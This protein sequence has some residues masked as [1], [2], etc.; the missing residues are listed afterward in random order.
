MKSAGLQFAGAVV[1]LLGAGPDERPSDAPATFVRD[2]APIVYE[3]CSGCHRPGEGAPFPLTRYEEVR[4]RSREI[5]QVT[6]RGLMPPWLPEAGHVP[7][8]GDR[9]LRPEEIEAFQRWH[10]AGAPLGE[11]GSTLAMPPLA[12][13]DPDGWRLGEPDL[14]L[15]MDASYAV[16]AEGRDVYRCFVLPNPNREMRWVRAVEFQPDNRAVLHHCVLYVDGSGAARAEDARSREPGYPGMEA[17]ARIPDGQ[18]FGWTPGKVPDPGHADIAWRLEPHT[19]VVLQLHLRPSGKPERVRVRLGLTFAAGPPTRRPLG[20]NISSRDL[21]IPAGERNHVVESSFV[22]PVEVEALGIWPHVHYLGRDLTGYAVLPDGTQRTL[23]HIPSWDFDW[24]EE[25]LFA[26]PITLSAGTRV[27]FRYVYDNSAENPL[28]PNQPP[29]RV[30]YGPRSDQEMAE[31]HL[32]VVP[33]PEERPL[34]FHDYLRHTSEQ[35]LEYYRNLVRADPARAEWEHKVGS[36]LLRL[37]RGAEAVE[38]YERLVERRP[39]KAFPETCLGEARLEAGDVEGAIRVLESAV[40]RR[41]AVPRARALLGQAYRAQGREQEGRA[42]LERAA[43]EAPDDAWVL[44]ELATVLCAAGELAAAAPLLQRAL[45]V[46]PEGITSLA[47][48]SELAL[49]RGDLAAARRF[50]EQALDIC[51]DDARALAALGHT[52][53]REANPVEAQRLLALARRFDPA[54]AVA[55]PQ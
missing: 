52:C 31:L 9:S 53:E 49:A 1:A 25:Y 54:G 38:L 47:A 41:D 12:T 51:P 34:L 36:L 40:A 30:V 43:A 50:A 4:R 33:R 2:I 11:P 26:E 6:E 3:K 14:V 45:A 22:V 37:G 10:A 32:Q 23:I 21:S 39:G 27:G 13:L 17:N 28:N 5:V 42:S 46:N 19:D 35:N 8:R 24:Q 16:P 7:L 44:T 18:F 20:I 48:A 29:H 15:E 55:R